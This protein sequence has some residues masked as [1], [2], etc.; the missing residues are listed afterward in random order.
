MLGLHVNR[1]TPVT[2]RQVLA[3][4]WRVLKFLDCFDAD[5]L[6]QIKAQN[7]SA[8]L[9]GRRYYPDQ[10][11]SSVNAVQQITSLPADV[12]GLID[13]WEV[14][15]EIL[16]KDNAAAVNQRNLECASSLHAAGLKYCALSLAVGTPGGSDDEIKAALNILWPG[17]A[18]SDAWSY[19]HYGAEGVLSNA[20]WLALRY[21][22]YVALDPRYATKP[23][24]GS[25]AGID[26]ITIGQTGGWRKHGVT[27]QTYAQQL[28][29]LQQELL[30]DPYVKGVALFQAGDDTDPQASTDGSASW[31]SYFIGEDVTDSIGPS[32]LQPSPPPPPSDPHLD[33]FGQYGF[34][35][36]P[37]TAL[38]KYWLL[39]LRLHALALQDQGQTNLANMIQPGP[40]LGSEYTVVENG[41]TKI[42]MKLT[43]R[44]AEIQSINGQWVTFQAELFK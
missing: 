2:R 39:P 24:I 6:R 8:I 27:A 23:L 11:I 21:R 10:S 12:L 14:F 22:K 35:P 30:K 42:R 7:P 37:E 15:N 32:L 25:E 5:L 3:H 41:T 36:N 13:Y 28:L 18:A 9:M 16:G 17:V 44:I 31:G 26:Y 43:N 29:D 1:L 34:R 38:Y 40:C 19:H 4:K 33:Y 20:E